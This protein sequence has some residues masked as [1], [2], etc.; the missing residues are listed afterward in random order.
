MTL[1]T[2]SHWYFIVIFRCLG[3]GHL[4][5]SND[6]RI[7]WPPGLTW[8]CWESAAIWCISIG[9]ILPD[10]LL[11]E[12]KQINSIKERAILVWNLAFRDLALSSSCLVRW[13]TPLHTVSFLKRELKQ[14]QQGRLELRQKSAYLMSKAIIVCIMALSKQNGN[15]MIMTTPEKSNLIGWVRQNNRT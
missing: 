14:W 13:E 6:W 10:I 4:I 1:R 9:R 5:T 15:D 11:V 7:R 3:N 8:F 2:R 12:N